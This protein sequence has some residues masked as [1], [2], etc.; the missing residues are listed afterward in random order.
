MLIGSPDEKEGAGSIIAE[1]REKIYDLVGK[2]TM[3][4][5][6]AVLKTCRLF[7]GLDSAGQHIAAAVGT[8]TLGIYGPSSPASWAPRGERHYVIQKKWSCVP[9]RRKGCQDTE[10]SRCLDD[11]NVDEV[12]AAVRRALSL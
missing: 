8:P 11:L 7:V 3:S 6:P 10:K 9:C 5:L 1:C 4:L 2:T 12:F